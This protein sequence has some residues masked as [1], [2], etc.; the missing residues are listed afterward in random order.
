MLGFSASGPLLKVGY[1]EDTFSLGHA[2]LVFKLGIR[3]VRL[4][5]P[6]GDRYFK[7][8]KVMP[9][10]DENN[11]K[12]SL[13]G[14]EKKIGLVPVEEEWMRIIH[15]LEYLVGYHDISSL[16]FNW[17][18]HSLWMNRGLSNTRWLPSLLES[19]VSNGE[20]ILNILRNSGI[21]EQD[22]SS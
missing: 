3:S 10:L 16:L 7:R 6:G 17:M 20:V 15:I 18:D 1:K 12:F 14:D 22:R 11:V 9:C 4:I 8:S 19:T 21:Q 2:G 5:I 13:K